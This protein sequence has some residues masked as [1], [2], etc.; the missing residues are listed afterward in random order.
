MNPMRAYF[1]AL[2]AAITVIVASW[3]GLPVSSTHIAVGAVFGVGFFRE[4][5]TKRSKRRRQMIKR[6]GLEADN[7]DTESPSP[8]V[9]QH[10]RLVRRAH[11]MTIV[12]AWVITVPASAILAA[13][14]YYAISI[15]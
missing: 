5:F 2:S 15:I 1:V 7:E 9:V 4:Q 10:R 11:F 13:V 6:R 14:A 12:V 3:L 8:D